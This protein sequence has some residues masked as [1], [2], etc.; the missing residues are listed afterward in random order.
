MSDDYARSRRRQAEAELSSTAVGRATAIGLVATIA[1]T[2]LSV[3][4]IDGA[5]GSATS[6][7]GIVRDGVTDALAAPPGLA[8]NRA[9]QQAIEEAE[10]RL[11]DDSRV[12]AKVRPWAQAGLTALLGAG[13]E[14][15]Y[16]GAARSL[17]YRP[18]VD[19]AIGRGFLEPRVLAARI[20]SPRPW[21]P[22][23]SPD[24][25]A[26]LVDF[27][28]RLRDRGIH[29][30]VVPV[31]VKPT[32]APQ[33]FAGADAVPPI[34]NESFPTFLGQL[35]DKG[36]DTLD[37]TATLVEQEDAFLATD[38]HWT[39]A[40]MEAVAAAL[41]AHIDALDLT[42]GRLQLSTLRPTPITATGDIVRLLDLPETS[43]R[44]PDQTVTTQRVEVR[45]RAWRPDRS[46]TILLLG[47]SFAN[48][49]S[50]PSLGWGASAGLAEHLS[51]HLRRPV[52]R[53]A[54]NAGG[55]HEARRRLAMDGGRLEGKRVVIYEFSVR[56]LT[57]GNWPL[58]EIG[59]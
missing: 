28:R 40:G 21:E 49:Y 3:P 10:S 6:W 30:I 26:A 45:G 51:H 22:T 39:P 57:S 43:Q 56:E 7:L 12:A 20:D 37:P 19:Y 48:I 15:A 46:A 2:L 58:I 47:D 53:I 36:I 54:V 35:A 32:L 5:S 52:D 38:T 16:P 23:I 33:L 9:L 13:N 41:A 55:A 17:F 11:E 29:L 24:P 44:Y 8:A 18:D 1:A 27:D 4:L 34:H 50:D 31:P 59:E 42:R 14:E 25:V